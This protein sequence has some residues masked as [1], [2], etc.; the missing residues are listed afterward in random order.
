MT[1]ELCERAV[2]ATATVL[3]D[4]RPDRYD[5]PTPCAGWNVRALINHLIGANRLFAAWAVGEKPEMAVLGA[6]HLADGEPVKLYKEAARAALDAF[7]T[8]GATDRLATLPSGDSGPR[9]VDM[10]LMEQVL[11]G[12]DLAAATGQDRNPDPAVTR[13]VYDAWYGRVPAAVRDL[14]TVFGP[15]QPCPPDASVADRLAAYLG[16]SVGHLC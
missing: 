11:H 4:V 3:R 5:T 6:D 10:Y 8:P 15:E 9:I 1:V 13:A 16:R 7:A 2:A 12:W 14:G